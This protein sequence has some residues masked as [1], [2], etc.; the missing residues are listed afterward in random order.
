MTTT[1]KKPDCNGL[2]ERVFHAGTEILGVWQRLTPEEQRELFPHVLQHMQYEML[3]DISSAEARELSGCLHESSDAMSHLAD[4]R[5][6]GRN[7]Y[8]LIP[9]D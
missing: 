7:D 3:G 1:E 9:D 5:D 4:S 8:V 2:P 6:P